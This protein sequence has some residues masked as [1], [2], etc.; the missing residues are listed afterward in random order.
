M[1]KYESAAKT[2][3]YGRHWANVRLTHAAQNARSTSGS[4]YVSQLCSHSGEKRDGHFEQVRGT[5]GRQSYPFENK[6]KEWRVKKNIHFEMNF[7]R[8]TKTII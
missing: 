8:M 4:A 3:R 1:Q 5:L 6:K 7:G 2:K